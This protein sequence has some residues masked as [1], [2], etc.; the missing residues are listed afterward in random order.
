MQQEQHKKVTCPECGTKFIVH[1]L[2]NER[3]FLDGYH[4]ECP[5]G[6][7]GY[8]HFEELEEKK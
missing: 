7:C 5:F 4:G 1:L 6:F 8:W 3:E 2:L